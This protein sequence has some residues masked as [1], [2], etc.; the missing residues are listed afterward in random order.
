MCIMDILV[1]FSR[2]EDFISRSRSPHN[3]MHSIFAYVG[4]DQHLRTTELIALA[5]TG[6]GME[7]LLHLGGGNLPKVLFSHAP[8]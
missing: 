6:I 8:F 5:G 2:T 7:C 3:A 1:H 4:Q